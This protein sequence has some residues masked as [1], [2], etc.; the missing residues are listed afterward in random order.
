MSSL[1]HTDIPK[2]SLTETFKEASAHFLLQNLQSGDDISV[3]S[4]KS[5]TSIR[6]DC[7]CATFEELTTTEEDISQS[8]SDDECDDNFRT[9]ELD[10][11]L[12]EA[13]ADTDT[14]ECQTL[15]RPPELTVPY[16][17]GSALGNK[18]PAPW[19]TSSS[20]DTS[21]N[22]SC[23]SNIPKCQETN[24]FQVRAI[25]HSMTIKG[26][27]HFAS[28]ANCTRRDSMDLRPSVPKRR[29]SNDIL[30]NASE[31]GQEYTEGSVEEHDN[32]KDIPEPNTLLTKDTK[33]ATKTLQ[34]FLISRLPSEIV[35]KLSLDEWASVCS[36]VSQFSAINDEFERN[37]HMAQC[38]VV[39]EDVDENLGDC[40]S[41][42]SDLTFFTGCTGNLKKDSE[43]TKEADGVFPPTLPLPSRS[44]Q[45]LQKRRSWHDKGSATAPQLPC[46]RGKVWLDR[47]NSDP[48][49]PKDFVRKF[50]R[51]TSLPSDVVSVSRRNVSFDTVEVRHYELVLDLN[52]S[53]TSGPS[54]GIGWNYTVQ[55]PQKVSDV[56]RMKDQ[57]GRRRLNDIVIPRHV[58]EK[59]LR[60][61]GYTTKQIAKAVRLNLRARNQRLQTIHNYKLDRIVER[62]SS[63]MRRLFRPSR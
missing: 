2:N 1:Q 55:P 19:D 17:D 46:R 45:P 48:I 7:V 5:N 59:S 47:T 53:T 36:E 51:T 49:A 35:S 12:E 28:N 34:S 38:T 58:R 57:L 37:D 52:P 9:K 40:A 24:S 31:T 39:K 8:V 61:C 62:S 4:W 42:V 18:K 6:I 11:A 16:P 20:E 41:V 44:H 26:D 43:K 15:C 63:Q 32:A 22:S 3:D 33:S 29:G 14:S 56:E 10:E 50:S 30:S 60:D 25:E 13:L 27:D 21:K 54:V 23:D